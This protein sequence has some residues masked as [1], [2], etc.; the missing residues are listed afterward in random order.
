MAW[1]FAG[2]QTPFVLSVK[3]NQCHMHYDMSQPVY[4]LAK[5]EYIILRAQ[6]LGKP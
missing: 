5:L 3:L 1:W 2:V 4:P 6:N